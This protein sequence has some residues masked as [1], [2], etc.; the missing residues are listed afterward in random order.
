MSGLFANFCRTNSMRALGR[1]ASTS[2]TAGRARTC[3][4][5]GRRP[6]ATARVPASASSVSWVRSTAWTLKPSS[7]P[8]SS[9]L[10]DQ[11]TRARARVV[12]SWV[13][14]MSVAPLGTS[15][16]LALSA[17]GFIATRTSGRSPGVRMSWSA[18]CSWKLETP[19]SV[20]CGARISAGKFGNVARSLPKT[21]VS[22]V[23]RSPVSCMPS[24]ESPAIRMTTSASCSRRRLVM[25]RDAG[26]LTVRS[27]AVSA[28]SCG[29][30]PPEHRQRATRSRP[31]PVATCSYYG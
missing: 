10:L 3:S 24:P 27:S 7:E 29:C 28:G 5:C 22:W 20:P 13:S 11:P 16:M 18:K 15:P 4:C 30:L 31:G 17:A 26:R 12:K 9:G 8:S 1:A 14:T 19:A 23:N 21:A 6:C 2:R 25:R